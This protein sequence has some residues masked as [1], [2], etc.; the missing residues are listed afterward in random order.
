M[1]RLIAF[2]L[3]ALSTSALPQQSSEGAPGSNAARPRLNPETAKALLSEATSVRRLSAEGRLMYENSSRRLTWGQYCSSAMTLNDQGEFRRAIRSASQ[4]LFLGDGGNQPYATAFAKRDLAVSYLYSGNLETA[5]RFAK[6]SLDIPLLEMNAVWNVRSVSY[7]TL[8]DVAARRGEWNKAI[9]QYQHAAD[10]SSGSWKRLVRVSIANANLGAGNLAK[11][12]EILDDIAGSVESPVK[13]VVLRAQGNLALRTG[14]P[15]E[16]L[17]FF[18]QLASISDDKDGAYH[19]VWALEGE[20]RALSARG[21][22]T[23]AVKSLLSAIEVA[24]QVRAR[25]RSEE[26]KTGTFG[27]MQEV[28]A[29]AIDAL[30]DTNEFERALAVS[31][32]GRS[33]ALLDL[34]RERVKQSDGKTAFADPLARPVN[35]DELRSLLGPHDVVIEYHVAR[36]RTYVWLI[37]ADRIVGQTLLVTRD[38]MRAMVQGLR[39]HM[40]DR[41]PLALEHLQRLHTV[42][43]KPLDVKAGESLIVVPHDALHLLPF[44]A[45]HDGIRFLIEAASVTYAPSSSV[46]GQ[47]LKRRTASNVPTLVAFG[48]PE[49]GSPD[50]ALPGAEREVK[51]LQGL[52]ADSSVFL[53]DDANKPR[54]LAEAPKFSLVHVAAHAEFDDVDPLYSRIRLSPTQGSSGNL[55]AHEIYRINLGGA[56]LVTL[57]A[58]E[59]GVTRVTKGD[60]IWGF[61]RSFLSA[62]AP[63][64]LLSLW[65]VADESTELLMTKFY[66]GIKRSGTREALRDAQIE[67]LHNPKF[68]HP[69][70]WSAFNLTGDWR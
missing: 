41:S 11:A 52:F 51:N 68:S 13:E 70:F 40:T 9:E 30:V 14:R 69:F 35:L 27:E 58:C 57:S 18:R 59:S 5:E 25:F 48:N 66:G 65:P 1:F 19:R 20:A 4:A 34:M 8:G 28:F 3:F 47:I 17:S 23:G 46:L 62:G 42:L 50:L 15:D 60:E 64:L 21:D 67:L 39:T 32:V 38:A 53:K 61:S 56:T 31:E 43:V 16:A 29:A 54:F 63:A 49:L 44:Q 12:K 10:N 22:K 33:R 7:K 55:E 24:D 26:F 2:G 36:D 37:R 45:L 6:E